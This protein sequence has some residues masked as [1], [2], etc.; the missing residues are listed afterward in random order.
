VINPRGFL[1]QLNNLYNEKITLGTPSYANNGSFESVTFPVLKSEKKIGIYEILR[2][3]K[4][5]YFIYSGDHPLA[6]KPLLYIPGIGRR[7]MNVEV[8]FPNNE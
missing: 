1:E 7:D 2:T 3:G 6:R 4:N 8:V 5:I